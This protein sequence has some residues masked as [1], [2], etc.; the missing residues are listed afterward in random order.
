MHE[1]LRDRYEKLVAEHLSP[2]QKLAAGLRALPGENQAFAS[3]Q[4]A[5][6]FFN[7][8]ETTLPQ[9]FEPVLTHVRSQIPNACQQFVLV[10]A[11]WCNFHYKTHTSKKD[12]VSLSNNSDLGYETFNGLA[13]P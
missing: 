10:A 13:M 3:T 9:V 11:D 1:N 12:R 4:G 2:A 8:E 6:R 7:N 5:W